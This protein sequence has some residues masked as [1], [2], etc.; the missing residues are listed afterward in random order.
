MH[1]AIEQIDH[2]RRDV[3]AVADQLH[4][5]AR[6]LDERRQDRRV[7]VVERRHRVERVRERAKAEADREHPFAVVRGGVSGRA[8]DP[9]VEE[10]ARDLVDAVGL[11]CHRR[12]HERA[13]ARFDHL[14]RAVH[15]RL[16]DPLA[17][18]DAPELRVEERAFEV[19]SEASRA[20][21]IAGFDELVRGFRHFG[22]RMHHRLPRRGHDSG[23]V[24]G[25]ALT[26]V[27]ARC[28]F[29]RVAL[30][31]VEQKLVG[32]VGVNV[33]QARSDDRAVGRT[34]IARAVLRKD[35][36]DAASVDGDPTVG[37]RA[38]AE[39]KARGAEDVG[40]G[41]VRSDSGCER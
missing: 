28:D 26:S 27:R 29:D 10:E 31:A 3:V 21:R 35:P 1:R 9:L 32:T 6:F 30:I 16:Q 23:E 24:A 36:C 22:G 5:R 2:R 11:G 15:R 12:H 37:Q 17:A 7:A 14:L 39:R 18:M 8:H 41:H 4:R 25:R 20:D 13:A 33:D 40:V 19:D 34:Q 38:V